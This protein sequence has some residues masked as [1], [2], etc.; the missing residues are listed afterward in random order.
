ENGCSPA[1]IL[2]GQIVTCR[3]YS[4]VP[5]P[6]E[7]IFFKD[8][9]ATLATVPL[10]YPYTY[11]TT[12]SLAVGTHSISVFYPGDMNYL[13][14]TVGLDS[15]TVISLTS[16]L[17]SPL[18]YSLPNGQTQQYQAIAIYSNASTN[19]I[20]NTATWSSSDP[21]VAAVNATGF[22][23]SVATGVTNISVST[24][25]V[26]ASTPLTITASPTSYQ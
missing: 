4:P 5:S 8:G 6:S 12:S 9:N 11:F 3:I 21:S 26:T 17:L 1:T 16:I 24:G 23:A 25:N 13:P 19:D 20:T 10:F 14:A 22:V 18:N 7:N 2:I 15:V